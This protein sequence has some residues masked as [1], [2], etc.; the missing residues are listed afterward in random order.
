M[1][2]IKEEKVIIIKNVTIPAEKILKKF[3]FAENT[4]TGQGMLKQT[5][6][7][8]FYLYKA[9]ITQKQ[10]INKIIPYSDENKMRNGNICE[11]IIVI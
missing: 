1:M 2:K 6:L 5:D 8:F 3:Y 4:E 9:T 10:I 7:M 11:Y